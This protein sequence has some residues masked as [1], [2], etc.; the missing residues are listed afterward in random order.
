MADMTKIKLTKEQKDAI[1]EIANMGVGRAADSLSKMTGKLIELEVPYVDVI[2]IDEVPEIITKRYNELVVGVYQTMRGD[3]TGSVVLMFPRESSTRLVDLL[4]G[5][6][7]GT[8]NILTKEDHEVLVEIGNILIG[9]CAGSLNNFL[10]MG[11]DYTVPR[12]AFNVS[13][14]FLDFTMVGIPQKIEN[15]LTIYAKFKVSDTEIIGHL[16]LLLVQDSIDLILER[17]DERIKEIE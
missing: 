12:I 4:K 11:V 3:L 8:T 2:S 1:T 10:D 14:V 7:F 13:G 5:N 6:L 9:S 16:I 15:A 17:V